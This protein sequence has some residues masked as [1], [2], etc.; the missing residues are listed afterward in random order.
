MGEQSSDNAH[1]VPRALPHLQGALEPDHSR[2]RLQRTQ[3]VH[4]DEL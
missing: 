1:H 3:N 4:G 2:A